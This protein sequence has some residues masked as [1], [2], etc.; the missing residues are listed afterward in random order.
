MWLLR[1]LFGSVQRARTLCF[2]RR[3]RQRMIGTAEPR[4]SCEPLSVL[5]YPEHDVSVLGSSF[6]TTLFKFYK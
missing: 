1:R 4:Q 2:F 6:E 3:E 5:I